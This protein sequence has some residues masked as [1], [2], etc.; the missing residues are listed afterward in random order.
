MELNMVLKILVVPD[1][2]IVFSPKYCQTIY[3]KPLN[4]AFNYVLRHDNGRYDTKC[5]S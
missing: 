2:C 3:R 5:Y 4:M 1:V